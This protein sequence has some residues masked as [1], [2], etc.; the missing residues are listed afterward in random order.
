MSHVCK[1]RLADH[2]GAPRFVDIG[3]C[4]Y[5]SGE[6]SCKPTS[7]QHRWSPPETRENVTPRIARRSFRTSDCQDGFVDKTVP[8][9]RYLSERLLLSVAGTGFR[10][11]GQLARTPACYAG[12][13]GCSSV[14]P[15]KFRWSCV[16]ISAGERNRLSQA[17][18]FRSRVASRARAIAS[19]R[20]ILWAAV[21]NWRLS[22][23]E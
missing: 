9:S 15:A 10:S 19:D 6:T 11:A 17:A 23:S 21:F 22:R 8:T 1:V 20:V 5:R 14:A 16:T 13:R 18:C 7:G 3:L 2:P 12:S 4:S